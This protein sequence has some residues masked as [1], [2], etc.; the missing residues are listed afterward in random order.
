MVFQR[1]SNFKVRTRGYMCFSFFHMYDYFLR[2]FRKNVELS[3]RS[4]S[5]SKIYENVTE[6]T[7]SH[8]FILVM[9]TRKRQT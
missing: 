6:Y 7:F 1:Y 9:V 5:C 3:L 4:F 2:F 8:L